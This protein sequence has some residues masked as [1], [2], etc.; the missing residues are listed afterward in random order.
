MAFCVRRL[1]VLAYAN[2]FTLWHYRAGSEPAA[3][4]SA[5]GF[6]DEA[7]D[8]LA[9][10]DMIMVSGSNGARVL[11]VGHARFGEPVVTAPMC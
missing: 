1:S 6:F 8:M 11:A 10:G 4:S 7:A 9:G 3:D 5:E 2:G